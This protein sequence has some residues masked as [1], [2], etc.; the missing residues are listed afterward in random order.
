MRNECQ[1]MTR[2][3]FM[4][5]FRDDEK[6]NLLTPDD[7]TEV[8]SQILLGDSDFTKEFLDEILSDY[9]VS[10]LEIKRVR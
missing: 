6:L 4:T 1:N 3:D 9:S 10:H 5:F 7:R 2:E 8:F